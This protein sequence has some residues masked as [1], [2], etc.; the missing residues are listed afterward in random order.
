[1]SET[2]SVYR[3]TKKGLKQARERLKKRQEEYKQYVCS[4]SSEELQKS[5]EEKLKEIAEF[6]ASNS[7][8]MVEAVEPELKPLYAFVDETGEYYRG[9]SWNNVNIRIWYTVEEANR[10]VK[11]Y[12]SKD[13]PPLTLVKLNP[14]KR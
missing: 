12:R 8:S 6:L 5:S 4:L 10:Y 11:K 7:A 2:N 1:M 13:K 3:P 14:T 9:E